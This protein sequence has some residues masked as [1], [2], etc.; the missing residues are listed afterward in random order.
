MSLH[1]SSL[2]YL[3]HMGSIPCRTAWVCMLLWAGACAS[4]G[5]KDLAQYGVRHYNRED[6][7]AASSILE[8]L[9]TQQGYLWMGTYDGLTR[10]NG[11]EFRVFNR[12]NTPT[13]HGN[14]ITCLLEGKDGT[15]W[16]GTL[17]KGIQGF[18]DPDLQHIRP[19]SF[20]GNVTVNDIEQDAHGR[21]YAATR[22]GLYVHEDEAWRRCDVQ[23]PS[24]QT[25]S[26]DAIEIDE[27]NHVLFA[28]QQGIFRWDGTQASPLDSRLPSDL[29][30][31]GFL[32]QKDR[33]LW[34]G[35]FE[36]GLYHYHEGKI[37]HYQT[38]DGLLHNHVGDLNF[39]SDGNLWMGVRGGVSVLRNGTF[40]HFAMRG[41][42]VY[43]LH[44]DR[45]GGIWVGTYLHGLYRLGN[46]RFSAY[47]HVD[48]LE[49]SIIGRALIEFQGKLLIGTN[50]GIYELHN[51]YLH[52]SKSFPML[53]DVMIR[54]MKPASDGGLWIGTHTN[55]VFKLNPDGE[56][57]AYGIEQGL[58]SRTNRCVIEASDG[59]VWI[60]GNSGLQVLDK[61][62]IHSVP[63]LQGFPILSL[64]ELSGGRI[65][66]ATDG[67]GLFILHS[68]TVQHLSKAD[69]LNSNVVFYVHEDEQGSLWITTSEAG[70]SYIEQD[71]LY[72]LTLQDG[73]PQDAIFYILE[74]KHSHFWIACNSGIYRFEK[75]ALRARAKAEAA[76]PSSLH[77]DRMDGITAG[78]VT[79]VAHGY[80]DSK[81]E[82]WFPATEGVVSV[83]PNTDEAPTPAPTA[84]IESFST[85]S[86]TFDLYDSSPVQVAPGTQRF[87]F[88]FVGMR[89]DASDNVRYR[90]KLEGYDPEF[91]EIQGRREIA[92]TNLPPGTY[93]FVVNA[94]I[95]GGAWSEQSDSIS[96]VL[97]PRFYQLPLFQVMAVL[98]AFALIYGIIRIRVARSQMRQRQ[99]SEQVE[100]RTA[101]LRSAM[102]KAE[103][104]NHSKS[105]FLASVSHEVRNPMNGILGITELLLEDELS[106]D[107]RRKLEI[108]QSSARSL[109]TILND[110]LDYSK[111]DSDKLTLESI[112]FQI[113]S[114]VDETLALQEAGI[115]EKQ[116]TIHVDLDNNLPE[117]V[118]GDP[119]RHRQVLHNLISNAVKFTEHGSITICAK[120]ESTAPG[121]ILVKFSVSDTGIGISHD[122]QQRLFQVYQQAEDSTA[123]TYGGTGLG[124]AICRS[125]VERMG[126]TIHVDSDV[127][128]G[129]TFTFTSRLALSCDSTP[130][131]IPQNH[132]DSETAV[133]PQ[134]ASGLRLKVLVVDDEKLNLEIARAIF[135]KFGYSIHTAL[136]AEAAI[137]VLQSDC[138]DLLFVDYRMP[139]MDGATLAQNIRSRRI[140]SQNPSLGIVAITGATAHSERDHLRE[141]GIDHILEKP[142]IPSHLLPILQDCLNR[143]RSEV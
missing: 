137:Q 141:S 84:I 48:P 9:Q 73:M 58:Q 45:E 29:R 19:R 115:R 87:T 60:A 24:R 13:L 117:T 126:G 68:D 108:V 124:L 97:K 62:K 135:A 20:M 23:L 31:Q 59:R 50:L 72:R 82:L 54:S 2:P 37:R 1:I 8:I 101:E 119:L 93:R 16:L 98:S 142:L 75:E 47:T 102:D 65:A 109:L 67:N 104:A 28:T 61:G 78:G 10:F 44:H 46:T 57:I 95:Q 43:S 116:L 132:P 100:Q 12:A 34:F 40:S 81:G 92:Y 125:L 123:R 77:F 136:G 51:G 79:G 106:P 133:L 89:F 18:L 53:D 99:L 80:T 36:A 138:F 64:H 110:L 105:L 140:P 88:R 32:Y 70:I 122:V 131:P 112:P 127:G 90:V 103:Q 27:N 7:I 52:P 130:L 128:K 83:N 41:K 55:G 71:Q 14:N 85:E 11:V 139:D 114:I 69:G 94:G 15:L 120:V 21:I 56:T 86:A 49:V 121:S 143:K 113:R 134:S 91:Q 76:I 25:T 38:E 118:V 3:S 66:V 4:A 22:E 5:A 17:G 6:G 74:D 63:E 129:A 107:Q 39:D 30:V 96:F 111:L 33:G 35:T 42:M 26:I